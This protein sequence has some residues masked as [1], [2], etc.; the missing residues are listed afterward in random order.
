MTSRRGRRYPSGAH[1]VTV[2][3]IAVTS[4]RCSAW[5]RRRRTRCAP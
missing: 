3:A 1:T 2:T 5:G 4:L